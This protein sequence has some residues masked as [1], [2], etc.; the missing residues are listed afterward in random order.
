MSKQLWIKTSGLGDGNP[1]GLRVKSEGVT[2]KMHVDRWNKE[3][4]TID[5][6]ACEPVVCVDERAGIV[7]GPRFDPAI[8]RGV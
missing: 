1:R 5:L 8:L 4:V 6:S 3:E 7:V 2:V